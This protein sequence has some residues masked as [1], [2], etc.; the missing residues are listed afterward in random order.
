MT[1]EEMLALAK[2]EGIELTDEDLDTI[3]GGG[4]GGEKQYRVECQHCKQIFKV[5]E[6]Q[7]GCWIHCPLCGTE[8]WIT[9]AC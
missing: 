3:S 6:S 7:L 5:P 9:P 2:Q 8:I 1:P 4:W